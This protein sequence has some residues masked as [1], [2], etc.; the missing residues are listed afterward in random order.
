[1]GSL[2]TLGDWCGRHLLP[3]SPKRKLR[4]YVWPRDGGGHLGGDL[5]DAAIDVAVRTHEQE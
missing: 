1:M 2:P 3:G 5:G 4:E